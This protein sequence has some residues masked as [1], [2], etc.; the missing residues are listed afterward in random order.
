[1]EDYTGLYVAIWDRA[2][3]DDINKVVK[4]LYAIGN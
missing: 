1:M 4:I 2:V 3:E